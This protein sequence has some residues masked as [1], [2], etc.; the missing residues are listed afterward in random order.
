VKRFTSFDRWQGYRGA[1]PEREATMPESENYRIYWP[2]I[3]AVFAVQMTVLFAVCI[4][5]ANHS[6][7]TTASSPDVKAKL[8]TK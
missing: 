5:V 1:N 3:L 6:S 8:L 4:A 7:F 2:A